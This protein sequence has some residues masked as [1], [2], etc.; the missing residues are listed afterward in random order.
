MPQRIV[1]LNGTSS[2][3]PTGA[4]VRIAVQVEDLDG[5]ARSVSDAGAAPV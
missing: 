2:A 5:T 1:L 4:R 3:G